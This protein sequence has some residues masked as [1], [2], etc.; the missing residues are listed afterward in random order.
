MTN[1]IYNVG[2]ILM[3]KIKLLKKI[4]VY[5]ILTICCGLSN[6]EANAPGRRMFDYMGFDQNGIHK[7]TGTKFDQY[8]FDRNHFRA[9]GYTH[10]GFNKCFIHKDT[11]TE[12]SPEIPGQPSYNI[13][14]YTRDGI[15]I[16]NKVCYVFCGYNIKGFD[17]Y[18]R[19]RDTGTRYDPDGFDRHG[20]N[21]H[22]IHKD[23][24]TK[25]SPQGFDYRGFD[26]NHFNV[27]TQ[28]DYDLDNLNYLGESVVG[29][30]S[31]GLFTRVFG[32]IWR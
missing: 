22:G 26:S 31:I 12:Y 8:G 9:D 2:Y 16:Y 13:H 25:L 27:F 28:C 20:F 4:F 32:W 23:T 10:T 30:K 11:G 21:R 5:L 6:I 29:I 15:E 7:I 3:N 18:S 1:L 24:G 14:G 19:H 17:R